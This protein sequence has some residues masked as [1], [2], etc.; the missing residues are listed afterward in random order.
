MKTVF[1]TIFEGVEAKNILRTS[2]LET[3]LKESDLRLVLFTKSQEKVDYYKKEFNDPR[4]IYE[5]VPRPSVYG[6]DSIFSYLKFSML[7]TE[8]TR[9]R[10]RLA[11]EGENLLVPKLFPPGA[12]QPTA[13]SYFKYISGLFFSWI[14]ARSFFIKIA[15]F[16]DCLFVKRDFYSKYF[17][18]YKPDLVFLAHLFDEPEIHLLREAKR[19]VVKSIGFINSWDKTTARCVIR[20]LP[21]KLIVF[22]DIIK[23]EL[24]DYHAVGS[25][26]IFVG[27]IPQYDVYF[28]AKLSPR[29]E[30]FREIGIDPSSKLIIYAPMGSF[31]SSSD[32]GIID[33]L[34][35]LKDAGRF[36]RGVDI[37]VRFQPNDFIDKNELDKRPYL[38]YDY[39]GKRFS[40]KRGVDWDMGFDEIQHLIDTL[41]N[42]SLLICYS[43]SMSVDAAIFDK[44]VININFE[45]MQTRLNK[46]A[47]FFFGTAHYKN[48]I[49][50]GG[51]RMI[52]SEN[53][54]IEWVN[55]YLTDPSLDADGRRRLVEGQCKFADGKSGERIGK[56]LISLLS[57]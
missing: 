12:K 11:Y 15:R 42:M 9:L 2:I 46:S 37:L 25:T 51:I 48:A 40:V 39:P 33:L 31:F 18:K 41:H 6:L 1:I 26:E 24:L 47:T 28:Q 53:E 57:H 55:K 35:R 49:R 34:Y 23:K 7:N 8:T 36:G 17:N 38:K 5:V 30:F 43:S 3:L 56:Y 44:P 54:L 50:S 20:L 19:R 27:G 52:A 45:I 4:I 10:R 16:L 32:W 22:N 13:E 14:I 29:D 21:D